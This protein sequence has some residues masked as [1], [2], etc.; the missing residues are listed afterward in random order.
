MRPQNE[1]PGGH[2]GECIYS[3]S[4]TGSLGCARNALR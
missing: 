4:Q 2:E 1:A 3:I